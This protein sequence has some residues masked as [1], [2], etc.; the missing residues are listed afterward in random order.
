MSTSDFAMTVS[1]VFVITG[2]GVVACGEATDGEVALLLAEPN[3][4]VRPGHSIK[5]IP[6]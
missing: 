3:V 6:R 2:R 4:Q 1:A 5:T